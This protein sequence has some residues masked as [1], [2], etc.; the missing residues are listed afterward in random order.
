VCLFESVCGVSLCE[1]VC[2][3]AFSCVCAV[4]LWSRAFV[5]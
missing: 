2:V 5:L 4:N 1:R 3:L